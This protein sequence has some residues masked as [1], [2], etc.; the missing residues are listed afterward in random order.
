MTYLA[1]LYLDGDLCCGK[2]GIVRQEPAK[3][4]TEDDLSASIAIKAAGTENDYT[5]QR[6]SIGRG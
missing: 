6:Q 3:F 5:L 2:Y 4:I 1:E